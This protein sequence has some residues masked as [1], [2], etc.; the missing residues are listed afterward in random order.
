MPKRRLSHPPPDEDCAREQRKNTP[1][2]TSIGCSMRRGDEISRASRRAGS[3]RIG[4]TL[5]LRCCNMYCVEFICGHSTRRLSKIHNARTSA[6]TYHV[7]HTGRLYVL[8][9]SNCSVYPSTP[10]TSSVPVDS[11]SK[12]DRSSVVTKT[13]GQRRV[14]RWRY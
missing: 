3:F 14:L 5:M 4:W 2:G 11:S 6:I 1:V 10:G 12:K 8:F 7:I 9:T 13:A